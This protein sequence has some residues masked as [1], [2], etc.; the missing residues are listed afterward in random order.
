MHRRTLLATGIAG[1]AAPAFAQPSGA[2]TLRFVP[3]ADLSS[4]DPIWTTAFNVRDHGYLVYDTL[5]G[6]DAEHAIRPQ[7]AEGAAPSADG[8]TWTLRLREGLRFHDNEP[9]RAPDVIAS[10]ARWSKRD[11]F[12]QAWAAAVAEMIATDDRTV[13]F[14]LSRPFPLFM[15]ALGKPS[16]VVPFIMPERVA[17]T[18]AFQQITDATGS[19]PFRFLRDEWRPGHGAAYA[20]NDRYVPR[21][22]AP[23]G[24]TGGK[25]VHFDRFELRFIPDASTAAAALQTGEVDWWD[26]MQPD[27]VP[28]IRR[29]RGARVF[30]RNTLGT[31]MTMRFNCLHPPFNNAAVRRAVMLGINQRDYGLAI[32]GNNAELQDVCPSFF[33]CGTPYGD[34]RA[35]NDFNAPLRSGDIEAAKAALGRSGYAGEKVIVMQPSEIPDNVAMSQLSYDLMR[36]M[37][38]NVELAAMDWGT[39]V[40][41]R[42]NKAPG[43][44]NVFCTGFTGADQIDPA[45]NVQ[46]RANGENAWFGWPSVPGIE[47][48]RERWFNATDRAVQRQAAL[49]MQRLAFEHA[50]YATLSIIRFPSGLRNE[51]QGAL[52]GTVPVFWNARKG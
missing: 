15:A 19:G 33:T 7:M 51:V 30:V 14:R 34:L 32:M 27:V 12:G 47:A 10:L 6:T 18:D 11:G 41:R 22:E 13:T 35:I 28:V 31:F 25:V 52:T 21:N 48:A 4:I 42:A 9:V 8:L 20:K 5:F 24:T 3:F 46:M 26:Q 40:Q 38:M 2:R 29:S 36:R 43:Q 50:P 23:S 45:S 39:L 16:S 49:E 37:G 44:W 1:L 17:R